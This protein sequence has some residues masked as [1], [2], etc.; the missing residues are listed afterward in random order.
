MY[1]NLEAELARRN[2]KKG[3]LAKALKCTPATMSLKLN[4][5]SD[6]TLKEASQIKAYIGVDLPIEVLFEKLPR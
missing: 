6:I 4:G 2:I 3:D 5:K 1:A